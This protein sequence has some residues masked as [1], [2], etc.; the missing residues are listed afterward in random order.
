VY[1]QAIVQMA[2]ASDKDGLRTTGV[3]TKADTIE[4][5][6]HDNW[7]RV[8][9]GKNYPL[10]LGYF[11]VVN[12]SQVWPASQ[13]ASQPAREGST[14]SM[15]NVLHRASSSFLDQPLLHC[16]R[17]DASCVTQAELWS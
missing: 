1:L 16:C 17:C 8:L 3:L 7:L 6:T 12:P 5:G 15:L 10:T 11:C 9:Q 13:P 14:H 2:R 4:A